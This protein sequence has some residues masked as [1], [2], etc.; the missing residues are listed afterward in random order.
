MLNKA[1]KD[2][3]TAAERAYWKNEKMV[4]FCVNKT[5]L[6]FDLRGKIVTIDKHAAETNFCFGYGIWDGTYEDAQATAEYAAKS[7][8]YFL[9]ENH[10]RAG[11]ADEIERLNNKRWIAYAIP[12]YCGRQDILYQICLMPRSDFE[13][14]GSLENAIVLT[15]EECAAYKRKLVEACKLHHKKL[16]AYLKRYGLTK[17]NT[18][19]YWADE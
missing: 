17:V 19:S 5:L 15:D 16:T 9:R 8:M 2:R 3:L 6:I 13:Y 7:T 1:E 10:R 12:H 4:K 14:K 18:W 11:Y